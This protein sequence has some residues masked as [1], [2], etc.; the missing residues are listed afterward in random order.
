ML[1][2]RKYEFDVALSFAG[3]DRIYVSQLANTLRRR[4]V[5]VFY[6]IYEKHTLWGKNLYTH[7]SEVYQNKARYCVMFLSQHY[8]MKLWT[9]HEREAAQARAFLEH[10]EYILPVRLDGTH[11]PGIPTTICYLSWPP[12]SAKTISDA[13]LSK[14]GKVSPQKV[15]RPHGGNTDYLVRHYTEMIDAYEQA[16]QLDP[17]DAYT[18]TLKGDAL[19]ELKRYEE[20]L[21]AYEQA[22]QLDPDNPYLYI[23]KGHILSELE[24]YEEAL[25][26]YEQYLEYSPKDPFVQGCKG[27]VLYDLERYEEALDAC[28]RSLQL[29]PDDAFIHSY[30]G[31]ILYA[32]DCLEE[33]LNSY[34]R[35]LQLDSQSDFVYCLKADVLSELERYEEA[36]AAYE[37][38]IQLDPNY[39]SAYKGKGNALYE[40]KCYKEALDAFNRAIQL[41]PKDAE[42]YI[43]KGNT[44]KH[45]LADEK[46][47]RK[48][49]K[50]SPNSALVDSEREKS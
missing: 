15:K 21:A 34:E 45:I 3:E 50:K 36:L 42:V 29:D 9:N 33:A 10:E 1:S 8:A 48:L 17:K 14:L 18:Y 2:D 30:K 13:V 11:I 7:L 24:R 23:E 38:A 43:Y 20:A 44:L 22:I 32:L 40:L 5:K 19:Y 27:I 47:T 25:S 49:T 6:D 28:E 41:N 35:S 31:M 46:N 39:A 26:A 12:E 4:G 16:I 37:Q